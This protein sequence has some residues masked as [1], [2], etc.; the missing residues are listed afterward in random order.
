MKK[1]R[2]FISVLLAVIM[3]ILAFT[4]CTQPSGTT[5]GPTTATTKQTTAPVG[6][7]KQAPELDAAVKA[8]TL[9]A[10]DKRLPDVPFV[11]EAETVGTYG[12]TFNTA[13]TI[14]LALHVRA[15]AIGDHS[16]N[17]PWWN[18]E[19]KGLVGYICETATI[20]ADYKEF[21]FTIRKGIKWSDGQPFTTKDVAFWWNDVIFDAKISGDSNGV[22]S[23]PSNLKDPV[24]AKAA[25][26]EV[27]DDYT[28]VLKFENSYPTFYDNLWTGW[29]YMYL[30]EHYLK[31]FHY[32]YTEQATIDKQAKDAGYDN[33]LDYF[34]NRRDATVNVDLP[35][36]N[37]FILQNSWDGATRVT[38]N[39]NPY[40]WKVDQAGNQLPYVDKVVIDIAGD[41]S[42]IKLNTLNGDYDFMGFPI[43]GWTADVS[44]FK[45]NETKGN[46]KL[47]LEG[48]TASNT[49]PVFFN[50]N[51]TNATLASIFWK[52]EFRFAMSYALDRQN[53]A[54]TFWNIG[55]IQLKPRQHAPLDESIYAT[56]KTKT[57]AKTAIEYDP[58]KSN[59]LLDSIGLDKKNSN[60]FR[61]A[62]DGKEVAFV[63]LIPSYN[64]TQV[65][66][67]E[68]MCEE[69]RAV[70]INATMQSLDPNIWSD[71]LT[72][73]EFDATAINAWGDFTFFHPSNVGTYTFLISGDWTCF[74]A[75]LW[76]LWGDTN[77]KQGVEPPQEIKDLQAIGKKLLVAGTIDERK[78]LL[79]QAMD[80]WI[81][82]LYVIGVCDYAPYFYLVG[83]KLKNVSPMIRSP[84]IYGCWSAYA[85]SWQYFKSE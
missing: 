42:V 27:K 45:E 71:K 4:A 76:G 79:D 18:K 48:S 77:G 68:R 16:D 23:V 43:C 85:G 44:L 81:P 51:S 47:N 66:M 34:N 41:D 35:T 21:S 2:K 30:P 7:Y 58:A 55:P 9:P 82:N 37:A 74:E 50:F 73:N 20:D 13:C 52:K 19:Q 11:C 57:L 69:W 53:L 39:R 56:E 5:A 61:L 59:Q 63:V 70:G 14:G 25:T 8:G 10:V 54:A 38:Y 29:T 15:A 62:E 60:G 67:L 75:K 22:V 33:W 40:Y 36:M 80:Y 72:N 3:I 83:N 26:F 6:N 17:L 64:Q 84:W 28:F 12:G 65:S 32:K 31:Q 24:T 78:A 49:L 1:A 46:Y